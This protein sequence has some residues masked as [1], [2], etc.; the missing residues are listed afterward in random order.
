MTGLLRSLGAT[1]MLSAAMAA[2]APPIGTTVIFPATPSNRPN[3]RIPALLQAA[4]G[5]LLAFAE[6]RND[7]PGDVGNHDIVLKRSR[8]RGRTWGPEEVV[9]D[10]GTI[11]LVYERGPAGGTRYWDEIAFAR[12]DRAWVD[13]AP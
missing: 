5:S 7:G 11:G 3:H 12:F 9:L 4:D 1:A 6:K 10:D 13:G 2:D 8:D